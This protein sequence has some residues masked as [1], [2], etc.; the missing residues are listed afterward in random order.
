[1]ACLKL[2]LSF[3]SRSQKNISG[4]KMTKTKHTTDLLY[5]C[6]CEKCQNHYKEYNDFL[7]EEADKKYL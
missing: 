5:C 4:G 6:S 1:M 3:F 2:F 7:D